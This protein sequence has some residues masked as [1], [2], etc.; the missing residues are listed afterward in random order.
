[1]RKFIIPLALLFLL[2]AD[3]S[4]DDPFA[5]GVE[6]FGK[7][8]YAEAVNQFARAEDLD[9][10]DLL[11]RYNGL[12][13]LTAAGDLQRALAKLGADFETLDLRPAVRARAAY[14]LG[15]AFLALADEADRAGNLDSRAP[16]L[17]QAVNWLRRSLLDSPGDTPARNNLEY[18][19]KLLEKL[20]QQ[21]QQ[22]G[23]GQQDQDQD[24][25]QGENQQQQQGEGEQ[26]KQQQ[27]GEGEQNEQQQQQQG[28][29][30]QSEQNQQ[31]QQQQ[32]KREIPPDVARN[33]L[34]AARDAE[35]K[36][37]KMLRE[38]RNKDAK[39]KSSNKRDW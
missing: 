12:T 18:A 34:K 11:A 26:N 25:Q 16:E 15:T 33:L 8:L 4:T 21:Q 6:L 28:E 31:Q 20:Q 13:G 17:M 38:Q 24:Q 27:Q 22:Q 36:A 32:Q 23:E 1:M 39:K 9:S 5:R 29:G 35:L 30:E 14:N 3:E 19:N 2:A 10:Q 7:G 37:M